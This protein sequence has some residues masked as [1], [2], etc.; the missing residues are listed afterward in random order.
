M[1]VHYLERVLFIAGAQNS[2]K[3]IQL[4]SMFKDMRFGTEGQIPDSRNIPETVVLSHDRNLYLRLTSPHERGQDIE[5]FVRLTK[6]KTSAGRWCFAGALQVAS[7]GK[8]PDIAQ[9]VRRFV[10]Q[11]SPERTRICFLSPDRHGNIQQLSNI[12]NYLDALLKIAGVEYVFIDARNREA[13][14]L[15]LADFFH[16]S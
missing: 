5:D 10:S 16:F 9:T 11:L 3:S 1:A 14:G 13:N 6:V 12:Q 15:L 2:G 7:A 4:R 8:M